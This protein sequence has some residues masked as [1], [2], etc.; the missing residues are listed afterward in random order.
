MSNK[1]LMVSVVAVALL[2]GAL[3]SAA[4]AQVD[5]WDLAQRIIGEDGDAAR[6]AMHEAVGALTPQEMG[7]ELRGALIT[8]LERQSEADHT[9]RRIMASGAVD[10]LEDPAHYPPE[11]Q[12]FWGEDYFFLI[13]TVIGLQ[14]T[15]T[16][17]ALT[18]AL[19]AGLTVAEGLA[20]FGEDA[21]PELLRLSEGEARDEFQAAMAMKA[22]T[23]MIEEGRGRPLSSNTIEQTKQL[24]NQQLTTRVRYAPMVAVPRP[25]RT[26]LRLEAA[27]SLALA[28]GDPPLRE[29]VSTLSSD[30]E[31][32]RRL[33]IEDSSLV[34]K[35]QRHAAR[36]LSRRPIRR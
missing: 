17:P 4:Q 3:P 14:D 18:G 30:P 1:M 16:I 15:R 9:Y 8:A 11:M 7:A 29:I 25:S 2:A 12:A 28:L 32:V 20:D 13:E 34:E 23:L 6:K 35:V 36:A 27:S 33:G 10:G 31:A 24:V 19:G 21:A 22:L 5:Q 26:A